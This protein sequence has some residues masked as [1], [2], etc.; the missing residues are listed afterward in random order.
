MLNYS[1]A[2]SLVVAAAVYQ[3]EAFTPPT[4]PRHSTVNSITTSRLFHSPFPAKIDTSSFIDTELRNAAMKLHTTMQSPKE[5][6][7]EAP[8][9]PLVPYVQTHADYLQFLVDSQHVYQALEDI[10]NTHDE[11]QPFRN[12]GLERTKGLAIDIAF[13]SDEY[14][15][16]IPDV[17][18]FGTNYAAMLRKIDSIPE[19]MCHYYNYYFAHTAGGRMIGKKMADVLLD[20]KVLEFYKWDGNVNKLKGQVKEDIETLVATWSRDEKDACLAGT[21]AVFSG[22]GGINRYLGGPEAVAAGLKQ[23]AAAQIYDN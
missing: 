3:T 15:V 14:K 9:A 16:P 4:I 6:K 13:L 20:K 11:L 17:G 2:C 23:T 22:G 12:T 18:P 19:F 10:V 8:K 5:G 21:P 7:V 1:T